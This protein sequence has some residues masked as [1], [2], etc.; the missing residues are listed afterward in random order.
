MGI[1]IVFT[2]ASQIPSDNLPVVLS[3]LL[4]GGVARELDQEI[5]EEFKSAPRL[6]ASVCGVL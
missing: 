5:L 4:W 6:V 2:H 1:C 3:A